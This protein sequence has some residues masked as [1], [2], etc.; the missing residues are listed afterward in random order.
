MCEFARTLCAQE[1]LSPRISCLLRFSTISRFVA[2][3]PFRVDPASVSVCFLFICTFPLNDI[4]Y[5]LLGI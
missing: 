5:I 3:F 4:R 2:I 1:Y